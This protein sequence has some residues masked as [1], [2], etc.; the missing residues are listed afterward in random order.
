MTTTD[1]ICYF[2]T[3]LGLPPGEPGGGMTGVDVGPGSGGA[4]CILG[5]ILPPGLM[6]PSDLLSFSLGLSFSAGCVP[7]AA[8][9]EEPYTSVNSTTNATIR[10]TK[11]ARIRTIATMTSASERKRRAAPAGS[12]SM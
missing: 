11:L 12:G 5:S 4:T 3:T 1:T 2:G 9:G 8:Y 10:N 6:T 7:W